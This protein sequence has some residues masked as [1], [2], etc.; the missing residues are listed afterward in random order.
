MSIFLLQRLNSRFWTSMSAYCA[1]QVENY[2][3]HVGLTRSSGLKPSFDLLCALLRHQLA[4]VPFECLALH[5]ST[6]R[7]ISLDA[8][9]LFKKVVEQSR[10]GYC[11]ENNAFFKYILQSIGFRVTSVVCRISNASRGIYDGGWRAM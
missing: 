9:D 8:Q 2:F 7:L 5:Y 3:Q 6:T 4:R 11:L 10:G 1:E